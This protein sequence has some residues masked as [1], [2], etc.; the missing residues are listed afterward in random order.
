[1]DMARSDIQNHAKTLSEFT[2]R[3]IEIGQWQAKKDIEDARAEERE[4]VI[5]KQLDAIFKVGWAILGVLIS[6][7]GLAF[8]TFIVRGGLFI[9]S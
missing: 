6:G 5:V 3:F 9:S 7:F 4:K 2:E 1:M 8:I